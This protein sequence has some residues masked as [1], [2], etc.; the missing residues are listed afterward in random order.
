MSPMNTV[1][2]VPSSTEAAASSLLASLQSIHDSPFSTSIPSDVPSRPKPHRNLTTLSQ[3]ARQHAA[4]ALS[5]DAQRK[6]SIMQWML[7][8]AEYGKNIEDITCYYGRTGMC[9][10]YTGEDS[11]VNAMHEQ[12]R[13]SRAKRAVTRAEQACIDEKSVKWSE[14]IAILAGREM[15]LN[16]GEDE[17]GEDD[18]RLVEVM[19]RG[20]RSPRII[21]FF[22]GGKEKKGDWKV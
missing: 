10:S 22:G 11:A 19:V 15:S 18:E 12:Y 16:G 1:S 4:H 21:K 13:R 20:E 14:L 2:H 7:Q 17:R 3:I 9:T 8:G 6:T 5:A